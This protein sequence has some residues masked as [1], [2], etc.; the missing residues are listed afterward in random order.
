[1]HKFDEMYTAM[2]YEFFSGGKQIREHYKIYDEWL[3]RQPAAVRAYPA[4]P[5]HAAVL[6]TQ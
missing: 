1:M 4:S 3:A 6:V 2:P 5:S